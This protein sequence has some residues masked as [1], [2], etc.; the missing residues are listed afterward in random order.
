MKLTETRELQI[1]QAIIGLLMFLWYASLI[2][3]LRSG[4][5]FASNLNFFWGDLIFAF[6]PFAM[7]ILLGVLLYSHYRLKIRLRFATYA[8]LLIGLSPWML[9]LVFLYEAS[10]SR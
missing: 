2:L 9:Y 5:G 8:V 4:K 10:R 7:P 3:A 1:Q 6:L